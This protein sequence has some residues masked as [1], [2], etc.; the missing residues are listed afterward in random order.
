MKSRENGIDDLICKAEIKTQTREQAHGHQEGKADK[1]GTGTAMHPYTLSCFS[2]AQ[3]FGTLWTVACQT[4][5]SMG[6]SR[7]EI[8]EWVGFSF[9]TAS[10]QRE[11]LIVTRH[12]TIAN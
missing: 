12:V 9:S 5:L 1:L 2:R 3:P 7:Q 6:F 11:A 10:S 4:P 8:L